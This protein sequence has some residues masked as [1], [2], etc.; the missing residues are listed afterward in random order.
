MYKHAMP[1]CPVD[2]NHCSQYQAFFQHHTT[3]KF[4]VFLPKAPEYS[5]NITRIFMEK[6]QNI[7]GK[8]PEL[9]RESY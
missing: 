2:C 3:Q 4:S 5:G 8:L 1:N 9:L 7:Q 6:Y